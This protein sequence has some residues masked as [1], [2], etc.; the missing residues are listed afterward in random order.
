MNPFMLTKLTGR[1]RLFVA[2]LLLVAS[3]HACCYTLSVTP[4]RDTIPV[5]TW[6]LD[7]MSQS[8]VPPTDCVGELH[9]VDGLVAEVR[10]CDLLGV[11]YRP[12]GVANVLWEPAPSALA[13]RVLFTHPCVGLGPYRVGDNASSLLLHRLNDA[14]VRLRIK[15]ADSPHESCVRFGLRLRDS[16]T[17]RLV[18]EEQPDPDTAQ[19][20]RTP[21]PTPSRTPS[22]SQTPSQT[23]TPSQTPMPAYGAVYRVEATFETGVFLAMQF[24]LNYDELVQTE[25]K[26]GAHF[27]SAPVLD[28]ARTHV[29]TTLYADDETLRIGERSASLA[30]WLAEQERLRSRIRVTVVWQSG[31]WCRVTVDNTNAVE[32]EGCRL[33]VGDDVHEHVE[34]ARVEALDARAVPVCGVV[35]TANW[36]SPSAAPVP[37]VCDATRQQ[38]RHNADEALLVVRTADAYAEA[39]V[40]SVLCSD[41]SWHWFIARVSRLVPV[42]PGSGG[43]L[44]CR[45][46]GGT[47]V[48]CG[49]DDRALLTLTGSSCQAVATAADTSIDTCLG[50]MGNAL[51]VFD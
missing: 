13:E 18:A 5:Y 22:P 24:G 37:V 41:N 11:D 7:T 2:M 38:T 4:R 12:M 47:D 1:M 35:V 29:L 3:A 19:C 16:G 34:T 10:E 25:G 51:L 23:A 14:W 21:T 45:V 36:P 44:P 6:Y 33:F 42:K 28:A 49:S 48:V 50:P 43:S 46:D 30:Q 40:D 20:V 9:A 17:R 15:C 32:F 31:G 39:V 26:R 27:C 8:T